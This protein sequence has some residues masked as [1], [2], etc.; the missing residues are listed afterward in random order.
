MS[1]F[2]REQPDLDATHGAGA[3]SPAP[4]SARPARRQ[5]E[6]RTTILGEVAPKLP[7]ERDES[8][9]DQRRAPDPLVRQGQKDLEAG[10]KDTDRGAPM[11]EVYHQQFR[12]TKAPD[13]KP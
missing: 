1:T 6:T 8:G 3:K 7:H 2:S 10:L 9:S 4:R 5:A 12:R 11:D 13:R